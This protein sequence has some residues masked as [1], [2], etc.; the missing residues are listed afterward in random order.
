MSSSSAAAKADAVHY[1]I[2]L[3]HSSQPAGRIEPATDAERIQGQIDRGEVR[4]GP[5]AAREIAARIEA[6]GGFWG[7]RR[8]T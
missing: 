1:R 2:R 7:P 3:N 6:A 8:D 5:D 4:V